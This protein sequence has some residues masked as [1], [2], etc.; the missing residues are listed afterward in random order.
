ML[1]KVLITLVIVIAAVVVGLIIG[2]LATGPEGPPQGSVSETWMQPG[3][4]AVSQV[5]RTFVDAERVT[6]A[7]RIYDGAPTRTLDAFIWYPDTTDA[8]ARPLLVYS[9]GF[10]STRRGG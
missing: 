4:Y 1:K 2:Y 3:P 9:H 8:A 5:E 7:N 6:D 10:I